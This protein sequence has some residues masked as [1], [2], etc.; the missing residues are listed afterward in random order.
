MAQSLDNLINTAVVVV[1][2]VLSIVDII[3]Y[4]GPLNLE[5]L[6]KEALYIWIGIT[7]A[8]LITS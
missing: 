5:L 8:N 6:N 1:T 3:K 2:K 7:N 4:R